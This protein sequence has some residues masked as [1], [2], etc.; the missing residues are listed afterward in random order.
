[1]IGTG[2]GEGR[3]SSG[4]AVP[5]S[6]IRRDQPD[7]TESGGGAVLQARYGRTVDQGRETSGE[8][9]ASRLAGCYR[10]WSSEVRLWLSVIAHNMGNPARRDAAVSE[11]LMEQATTASVQDWRKAEESRSDHLGEG[12]CTERARLETNGSIRSGAG[13]LKSEF[14]LRDG[15]CQAWNRSPN[16]ARIG[17]FSALLCWRFPH[18][19]HAPDADRH[20]ARGSL[21]PSNYVELFAVFAHAERLREFF[22]V[23]QLGLSDEGAAFP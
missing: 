15:P 1:L 21:E 12:K 22:R 14:R 7:P 16:G 17:R 2:S 19:V 3:A 13:T 23:G 5:A 20:V 8:N 10:F 6:G 9:D 11:K 4:G 18:V